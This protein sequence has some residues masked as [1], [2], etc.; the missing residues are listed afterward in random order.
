MS[1]DKNNLIFVDD[2]YFKNIQNKNFFICLV[3]HN[4]LSHKQRHLFKDVVFVIDHHFDECALGSNHKIIEKAGSCATLI[5]DLI[6]KNNKNLFQNIVATES[7]NL[8]LSSTIFID[9]NN[10][11]PLL[12]NN[13][14]S[15]DV[16][17]FN[18]LTKFHT[19]NL[20][21]RKNFIEKMA[22]M[23]DDYGNLTNY[24][25]LRKDRKTINF[26]VKKIELN[27]SISSIKSLFSKNILDEMAKNL[28]KKNL[29][30][31]SCESICKRIIFSVAM[32]INY[33][34]LA[35]KENSQN[36]SQKLN[37][38]RQL[39][40]C[41]EKTKFW[42]FGK[43]EK[44]LNCLNE[45]DK[46]C[47]FVKANFSEFDFDENIVFVLLEQKNVSYSRKKIIFILKKA[48]SDFF[49]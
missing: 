29:K 21:I 15:K 3:D 46:N 6:S 16:N 32:F 14:S 38:K 47:Y 23:K 43:T 24:E 25:I 39:L 37:L 27:V 41:G 10:F 48:F 17:Y 28:K 18:I 5:F 26:N 8:L 40:I 34:N 31:K 13:F 35:K 30:I 33:E 45:I 36:C 11:N 2:F 44:F 12:K 4:R 42:N 9:T 20:D 1:I 49:D 19:T 22:K 7:T